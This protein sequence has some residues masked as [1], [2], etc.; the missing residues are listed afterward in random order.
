MI[1]V[2]IFILVLLP[3]SICGQII[4]TA[5]GTGSS[6]FSGNGV[7]A[8]S[9]GIPNPRGA[10][11][12]KRGN[13]IFT[14]GTS[15]HRVRK[16]D[17]VG[18]I[19]TVAGTGSG[20]FNGDGISAT[21]AQLYYPVAAVFDTFGNMY[22]ADGQNYRVRKVSIST[23]EISTIA[24][25]GISGF[26]GDSGL[27]TNAKI[28]G[29]ADICFDRFGNLYVADGGYRVRKINGA[30]VINTIAGTG[31]MGSI[32]DGGPATDA[33]LNLAQGIACD[34]IGNIY[35]A[36]RGGN[37][38]RKVNTSGI[39][40][41]F[42]GNGSGTFLGDG[43]PATSAQIV[44]LKIGF[45][46]SEQLY[47]ADDYNERVLKVDH[48]GILHSVVGIGIAGY[49]GDNGL[50]TLARING[51]AGIAFDRCG[52]LYFPEVTNRIIRKV[53]FSNLAISVTLAVVTSA[54]PGDTVS[55]TANIT[56]GCCNNFTISWMNHGIVFATTSG[57]SATYIKGTGTDSITAKVV[58]C[59]DTAVSSVHVVTN[60][61]V[62]IQA[63]NNTDDAVR[64]FPNPAT[65]ELTII[66]AD[67]IKS[68]AVSNLIGQTVIYGE[69]DENK[70]MINLQ[71]LPADVYVVKVSDSEGRVTVNK[72]IKE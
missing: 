30:G 29:A 47:I 1:R 55:L 22:I 12:D 2:L 49:A 3:V 33:Q 69:F 54:A 25:T 16:I 71:Y 17:S 34:S 27:A 21:S 68:V 28:A 32:G 67:K 39:I 19:S 58:G 18:V 23:G 60:S 56:R 24:G 36:E 9:A 57:T 20:G 45:D 14:D 72:V 70:A 51:P 52:N 15:S 48:S 35:I 38:I 61:K 6:V 53:I 10:V 42:A 46:D 63:I 7:P 26:S 59:G 41:T 62:G 11:F 4:T 31:T 8:T 5:G 50:A 37:R 64:L 66:A 13:F 44:P 43:I 65:T 40:T